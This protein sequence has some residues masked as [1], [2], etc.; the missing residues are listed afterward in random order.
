MSL[1]IAG[2]SGKGSHRVQAID[3]M[4]AVLACVQSQLLREVIQDIGIRL[5]RQPFLSHAVSVQK[6]SLLRTHKAEIP[7][8]KPVRIPTS[9]RS[10]CFASTC[11]VQKA[12]K[13]LYKPLSWLL[14][15]PQAAGIT[16]SVLGR[17]SNRASPA[18]KP[19]S[20][21]G[22]SISRVYYLYG[23]KERRQNQGHNRA[24]GED[25]TAA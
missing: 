12:L 15:G 5:K 3:I 6:G 17:S 13:R 24:C 11:R 20:A 2:E 14:F 8:V 19:L 16:C 22:L 10:D 1:G 18:A 9:K 23:V 7:K 21:C 25:T 4:E